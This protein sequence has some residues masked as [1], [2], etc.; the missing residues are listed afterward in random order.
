MHPVSPCCEARPST[1]RRPSPAPTATA[2]PAYT[3]VPRPLEVAWLA[4]AWLFPSPLPSLL[5]PPK[6]QQLPSKLGMQT[7]QRNRSPLVSRPVA[8]SVG[9]Y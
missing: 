9:R 1:C 8:S 4:G 5:S 7:I 3:P 6:A 2:P